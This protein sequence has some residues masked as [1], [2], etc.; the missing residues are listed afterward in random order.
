MQH[1]QQQSMS[2]ARV[3]FYSGA[4][5]P[6]PM[7]P[8]VAHLYTLI[9]TLSEAPQ[10]DVKYRALKEIS[11][12]LEDLVGTPA[13][14]SLV[15][16]LIRVFIKLLQETSP[17]FITENNT[18]QLRKL[19]LDL[20]LR[21][22]ANEMMKNYVK[23][24]QQI[25]L[26]LIYME[27]EENALIIIKILTDH[28][29]TFRPPFTPDLNTFFA[30]SKS[31]FNG[32]FA[33]AANEAMFLKRPFITTN[34][35]IEESV[36]E[37]L[38]TCYSSA[39]L[40]Y[41]QQH[42]Y[43]LV[44]RASQ[45]VK[46]LAEMSA[47]L[48]VLIQA[49]RQNLIREVVELIP[50]FVRYVNIAVPHRIREH[51]LY[52]RELVEEF[53]SS[54]VRALSFV[55]YT[56]R[57]VQM[58]P[59]IS[60]NAKALSDGIINLFDGFHGEVVGQ[61]RDLLVAIKYFFQC[62][63][64]AHFIGII[65]T[66]CD[67]N[68]LLGRSF[69]SQDQLR[70]QAYSFLA[71]I[72]H[73]VRMN[74]DQKL[75]M[76]IFFIASRNL[77]DAQLLPYVQT[78]YGKL[79][80][81]LIESVMVQ[82]KEH[83]KMF[84]EVLC[85]SLDSFVRKAKFVAEFH[86]PLI[87]DKHRSHHA[88]AK[89]QQQQQQ[90]QQQQQQ[91]GPSSA[92]EK[93]SDRS[94]TT[95]AF[96]ACQ[97]FW[98]DSCQPLA[99]NDCKNM[100]RFTIQ[101]VKMMVI[102]LK[103][104]G[105]FDQSGQ[106]FCPRVESDSL[107]RV[108]NLLS[109][110]FR[111]GLKC[112][113][114][115]IVAA[116]VMSYPKL[117]ATSVRSKEEKDTIEAF[118]S[119]YTQLDA[120]V[121][122]K[123]IEQHIEFLISRILDNPAL[124]H[125]CNS[126]FMH[127]PTMTCMGNVLVKFLLSKLSE[128]GG[129]SNEKAALHLKLFKLVFQAVSFAQNSAESENLLKPFLH[130]I[131]QDSMRLA[132]TSRES[133]NYFLLLRALFRSIGSGTHDLLYQQF[134]PL[135]PS[136]LQQL[137]RLQNGAHRQA[138]HELFVELCLTIPV[139]LSSLLP[140]LPLLMDPL[141]CALN[142]SPSLVQQGLRTLELCVDN[143]QPEYLYEHMMPVRG[144]LMSGL[145]R[146]V[147]ASDAQSALSA[148][149]ILGK[150]GGSNRK[151]L[152]DP[153]TWNC[154]LPAE[155]AFTNS[156]KL[157]I[158]WT[159]KRRKA[160]K[161]FP[162]AG[163]VDATMM[164]ITGDDAQQPPRHFGCKL[165][166]RETVQSAVSILRSQPITDAAQIGTPM[167]GTSPPSNSNLPIKIQ[168]VELIRNVL[169][170]GIKSA[171]NPTLIRRALSDAVKI[172]QTVPSF[173]DDD[174]RPNADAMSAFCC[175]DK[176]SRD[177]FVEALTGLFIAVFNTETRTQILPFFK[178][179]TKHLTVMAVL[180][181][182]PANFQP[183]PAQQFHCLDSSILIDTIVVT[184]G[185]SCKDYCHTAIVALRLMFDTA[186]SLFN[187]D[188]EKACHL[189][190]F[191]YIINKVTALCYRHEWFA[192]HG[193]C[194]AMRMIVEQYPRT[195]VQRH[196]IAIFDACLATI[197]GLSD[198]LSC[199]V[200]ESASRVVDLLL[201]VCFS[202]TPTAAV[203]GGSNGVGKCLDAQ[204]LLLSAFM[205]RLVDLFDHSEQILRK[206]CLRI[207]QSLAVKT[208]LPAAQLIAHYSGGDLHRTIRYK[209]HKFASSSVDTKIALIDFFLFFANID[210]FPIEFSLKE[211][212]IFA[213]NLL[214]ICRSNGVPIQ[215][216]FV[217]IPTT[218]NANSNAAGGV[219]T[220][221]IN[222]APIEA[223]DEQKVQLI[224][225]T[226]IDAMVTLYMKT[227]SKTFVS[228]RDE[229]EMFESESG[230]IDLR[231][232]QYL[233]DI[234]EFLIRCLLND[235]NEHLRE[236]A[237]RGLTKI[238]TEQ[239][240]PEHSGYIA[241]KLEQF[242]EQ[243]RNKKQFISKRFFEK[244]LF[245]TAHSTTNISPM[246]LQMIGNDL[247][248]IMQTSASSLKVD[249]IECV[250]K[251][252]ELFHALSHKKSAL[253]REAF[254]F[255]ANC[256]F[257]FSTELQNKWI[258]SVL[259]F[260]NAHSADFADVFLAKE[261][262]IGQNSYRFL[263]GLI[264]V[265][266][267]AFLLRNS[268]L[269]N[270]N[271]IK[272]F[273]SEI[274]TSPNVGAPSFELH[275]LNF[276]SVLLDHDEE[277]DFEDQDE[278]ID[279]LFGTIRSLW[280]SN[281]FKRRHSVRNSLL[282]STDYSAL[283]DD[284]P[285][286]SKSVVL[287][288]P[289]MDCPALCARI[290]LVKLRSVLN[291]I[292]KKEGDGGVGEQGQD[293]W[294][295]PL[296]RESIDLIYDLITAFD[297]CYASDFTFLRKF[298]DDEII[299]KSSLPW[300]R[301]TFTKLIDLLK[302]EPSAGRSVQLVRFVQYI[303]SPVFAYAFEMNDVDTVVCAEPSSFH[304][305]DGN[306]EQQQQRHHQQ[307]QQFGAYD[308]NI[309]LLLCHEVIHRLANERS[310]MSD[311]LNIVMYLFCSLVVQKCPLHI[312]DPAKRQ[313][314]NRQEQGNLRHFMLFAWPCLQQSFQ[315]DVTEKYAGHFL[316]A[317]IIDK[318]SIIK[319][320]ILQV[321]SSLMQSYHHDN[322]DLVRKSLEILIPALPRRMPDGYFR[323]QTLFKKIMVEEGRNNA[324]VVHC[325]QIIIRHHK[326]FYNI[327]HQIAPHILSALHRLFSL[328]L[329]FETRRLM[330]EVCEVVIKWEQDRQTA[331][332][333]NNNSNKSAPVNT[334]TTTTGD[335]SEGE[336][337]GSQQSEE[338]ILESSSP[339][340][341]QQQS[342]A[343]DMTTDVHKPMD[344]H[345]IDSIVT[346]IF[347]IATF[348]D[349]YSGQSST[350]STSSM[351]HINR[352][353]VIL[354]RSALKPTVFGD[355]ATLRTTII[356][357]QL[358]LPNTEQFGTG[359][360]QA[361]SHQLSQVQVTLDVLTNITHH[362][363]P[364]MI[365][366]I[367]RPL[368]R[369]LVT[370]ISY[371]NSQ[372]ILRSTYNVLSKLLEKTKCSPSGLDELDL[373]NHHVIRVIQD[374]FGNYAVSANA[375]PPMTTI[376]LL[377][378][379]HSAQPSY[380]E[381]VCLMP[382]VKLLQR[383][384]REYVVCNPGT[385]GAVD[386]AQKLISDLL[387]I[388][389][390]MLCTRTKFFSMESQRTI[391]QIVLIPL[392]EKGAVDKIVENIIKV[393]QEIVASEIA[394]SQQQ[395]Q[396]QSLAT[397]LIDYQQPSQGVLVLIKL[398]S[399]MEQRLFANAEL[400]RHF[401]NATI[402]VYEHEQLLGIKL[403]KLEPAFHWGL[404]SADR[405][406]RNKF[407]V[408]F[409]KRFP[410]DTAQRLLYIIMDVNWQL[411]DRY[412]W[413][414]HV[415][416]LL[417]LSKQHAD[418]R[419]ME[420]KQCATLNNTLE[421]IVG[422][423]N[424]LD[425]APHKIDEDGQ[426]MDEAVQ[427]GNSS[428]KKQRMADEGCLQQQNED[429]DVTLLEGGIQTKIASLRLCA[430]SADGMPTPTASVGSGEELLLL[431]AKSFTDQQQPKTTMID[432]QIGLLSLA[433]ELTTVQLIS[434]L[435]D[436]LHADTALCRKTF[437]ELFCSLWC[438]FAQN[439]REQV[440]LVVGPFLS[441][442]VHLCQR[443]SPRAVVTS[444]LEAFVLCSPPIKLEPFMLSY[445]GS[446]FNCWHV[447]LAQLERLAMN[448]RFSIADPVLM[449]TTE[450]ASE[451][452]EVL[453]CLA[454]LY[455]QLNELDQYSALWK[456]RAYFDK[457]AKCLT[458]FQQ[459]EFGRARE[460]AEKL[461][462]QLGERLSKTLSSDAIGAL[463]TALQAEQ[464]AWEQCWISS[465][466]QLNDWTSLE[467]FAKSDDSSD[468]ALAMESAW[469]L[470]DWNRLKD[471]VAKVDAIANPQTVVRSSMFQLM[472]NVTNFRLNKESMERQ[473]IDL[474]RT[475]IAEWRRLPP[476]VSHGHMDILNNSH[477]LHEISESAN[478]LYTNIPLLTNW[479][480]NSN[481]GSLN[482]NHMLNNAI[483]H[484]MKT[485]RNR[486]L[487]TVDQNSVWLDLFNW[488]LQ[489]FSSLLRFYDNSEQQQQ[490]Q[491]QSLAAAASSPP[492]STTLSVPLHAITQ[493]HLQQARAFRRSN[494]LDMAQIELNKLNP[495]ALLVHPMDAQQKMDE[496]VK[497]L[498]KLASGDVSS[499]A[500]KVKAQDAILE[501]LETIEGTPFNCLKRDQIARLMTNK[502]IL[503]SRMDK[504][505]EAGRAFS[506]AAQLEQLGE[507][508]IPSSFASVW[509]HWATFLGNLYLT[510]HTESSALNTG[511][512]AIACTLE[513]I[514]MVGAQK[515]RT[516]VAKLFWLLK[517]ASSC[518]SEKLMNSVDE[519]LLRY[520]D[521]IHPTNWLFWLHEIVADVQQRKGTAMAEIL[522]RVGLMYPQEV[523]CA[524]RVELGPARVGRLIE[525]YT[526]RRQL[527][528]L[529]SSDVASPSTVAV[530]VGAD[531]G[532]SEDGTKR[533]RLFGVLDAILR[534]HLTQICALNQMMD[535]LDNFSIGPAEA[536]LNRFRQILSDCHFDQF[537]KIG[538]LTTTPADAQ[539]L[540]GLIEW[541]QSPQI[542]QA[543]AEGDT[544]EGKLFNELLGDFD[545]CT[546]F[547]P[548][549]SAAASG[550]P[551]HRVAS[552]LRKWVSRI[553]AHLRS[554]LGKS[555]K[556]LADSSTFLAQ[557][558]AKMA[559]INIFDGHL[560]MGTS[561]QFNAQIAQFVP[562]FDEIVRAD[563]VFRL[564]RVRALNGKIYS[565]QL[566]RV[567]YD[568]SRGHIFQL[569]C[570]LN[571]EFAKRRDTARRFV[572][573]ALPHILYIGANCRLLRCCP[574]AGLS[575]RHQNANADH[576]AQNFAVFTDIMSE[577]LNNNG[578]GTDYAIEENGTLSLS[579]LAVIDQY[580]GRLAE[581]RYS[582][583][584]IHELFNQIC[585][586]KS[587][588]GTGGGDQHHHP[589]SA[590][591]LI[592]V[593]KDLLSRWMGQ[594]YGDATT[595]WMAR[596][597]LAVQIA[598]LGLSEHALFL[599]SMRPDGLFLDLSTGQLFFTDYKFDLTKKVCETIT[600]KVPFIEL[601]ANRPVP[602]RLTP[603]ISHFL[604]LSIDGHLIG[605]LTA[606]A[607]SLNALSLE[608]W[609]RPILWDV[610]AKA[611]E[612]DP[613]LNIVNPVKRAVDTIVGR[614]KTLSQFDVGM[615]TS[616]QQQL[617]VQH[618]MLYDNLCRMDP[619]WHPWHAQNLGMQ[620]PNNSDPGVYTARGLNL[621]YL[622]IADVANES[623][624]NKDNDD[625]G[626]AEEGPG[627]LYETFAQAELVT[628]RLKLLE[629]E[630]VFVP[631]GDSLK[632]VTRHYF[633]LS[634]NIG[635]QF[636]LFTSLC[637]W[638]I[639]LSGA[640]PTM[641]MPHEFDDPNA[642]VAHILDALKSKD[643]EIPFSAAKLKTGA[644]PQCLFVL[645]H[646]TGMAL[647]RVGF[648]FEAIN[649]TED[650][651][652]E[653]DGGQVEAD[654]AELNADQFLD[655]VEMAEDIDEPGEEIAEDQMAFVG[656]D[657]TSAQIGDVPLM[658]V[659]RSSAA[660]SAQMDEELKRVT[661]QLK[662]TVRANLKDWRMH[663]EQMLRLE[664]E[665]REQ[666]AELKPFM[667][668]T[669]E[670][671][672][673][674]M[675]RIR[676]R[677]NHL[678]DQF[679]S[680]LQ[681]YRKRQNE[682]AA[683][684][685]QY[686]ESSGT[687]NSQT[688]TLNTLNEEI[689]QLKQQIDEQGMQNTSGAPILKIKQALAKLDRDIVV[690]RV[691]SATVEQTL[692]KSQL[693]DR[694]NSAVPEYANYS[695]SVVY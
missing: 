7:S 477:L 349:Q 508:A 26:R 132:V 220:T 24:L 279:E 302:N 31:A 184:L 4:A 208:K 56:S 318:F 45:S 39:T 407:F 526:E 486:P 10:D 418:Q 668:R 646:L 391:I 235:D 207:F 506:A 383:L 286:S 429:A 229:G 517:I 297:H 576:S 377:R 312:Y 438:T 28:I 353:A 61:R 237:N 338:I 681:L 57:Q 468:A 691:Q 361:I 340:Q 202:A 350:S 382:F 460:M 675:E 193:G 366:D 583:K 602:F 566:E 446:T 14:A 483:K 16:S 406:L 328:Q 74:L 413:V 27:N 499:T 380:L 622:I 304:Q 222:L 168:A 77:H 464:R 448:I 124:Q 83:S 629:Y 561:P 277:W 596:K 228:P 358:Q 194:T 325:L 81:N 581:Q 189:P 610:F 50:I 435:V 332:E 570:L 511:I 282:S 392:I 156:P 685:E 205:T 42:Q 381:T 6:S 458:L 348:V 655:E 498:L 347:R 269:K 122:E 496:H 470:H 123:I 487:T 395:Q 673:Q 62:E 336:A 461:V 40:S 25:L 298:I 204:Q 451:K 135:L 288:V 176:F 579:P 263:M 416:H 320:I 613:Q 507:M 236:A 239:P 482:N 133:T 96:E 632:P 495:A 457:T 666:Y 469:H 324:Q 388:C 639:R 248:L 402:N 285:S 268:L 398:F 359:N 37:A 265:S 352:R 255:F 90:G 9:K 337:S 614:V 620:P 73:H 191:T 300:R 459:G 44:P 345:F 180:E 634:T 443:D 125:V 488:R 13:Y 565:Y 242:V 1:Q 148:L 679:S 577:M 199:G 414:A 2:P 590:S 60:D 431:E 157:A 638:L 374:S 475:M 215:P 411:M 346:F 444:F 251:A 310:M 493:C 516:S 386:Q 293:G 238:V 512:Q 618:S 91:P 34:K 48:F 537:T 343:G 38:K 389:L 567:R 658:E 636:H 210:E 356:E 274:N 231:G 355:V 676:M 432:M 182:N 578:S 523:F 142:G 261:F 232:P 641:K 137:N 271:L 500:K 266:G 375:S 424:M 510:N 654:E 154:R 520:V 562:H 306:I 253:L 250:A 305:L 661:P 528:S 291:S 456:R 558:N 339:T 275:L 695:Q 106:M 368:Q 5:V 588:A 147:Y 587:E 536:T 436:I 575:S 630:R 369:A 531:D 550:V 195:F 206:E 256:F 145:W 527:L 372:Q 221:D 669:G 65:P 609:L 569:F 342:T 311:S 667:A 662:V 371:I 631:L 317:N 295:S 151:A 88:D 426:Q 258:R 171:E 139:R 262:L 136:I 547:S 172:V 664:R 556:R 259:P 212:E 64:R 163:D 623:T 79:M 379:M 694:L 164:D 66:M 518:P 607:R 404:A 213:Q 169:L 680:L 41:S 617:L 524:L 439:E 462:A 417:L 677:E 672:E 599:S 82:P 649:A 52:N 112:L 593:Q 59:I 626:G 43:T 385:V 17:Q 78:M 504:R 307:Q 247:S 534:R 284:Q 67:D 303:V 211:L 376:T 563:S 365:I 479:S 532:G 656:S 200:I 155:A 624:Q 152:L 292:R 173:A 18:L 128:L 153:Q 246:E 75:L 514:W 603:N 150:F 111:Y 226:A 674:A 160:D 87:V 573:F 241:M 301:A 423:V 568:H 552:S 452:L 315:G 481:T 270:L 165:P 445:L 20:L 216:K 688:D 454:K 533:Q 33:H 314:G 400:Q 257:N 539:L 360:E 53:H 138:V 390:E 463:S 276:L 110:F 478:L 335:D 466:K 551:L 412:D 144:A 116:N 252:L 254:V 370:C 670:E 396:Q 589:S 313:H 427:D 430:I 102:A 693:S 549:Q 120:P 650:E 308:G 455:Q 260:M 283:G 409:E 571:A 58:A 415:V 126:F 68:A 604:G 98:Q 321:L 47:F 606:V 422:T 465:C 162:E 166:L 363:M 678:N 278:S 434:S 243:F 351:E 129:V 101:P 161:P 553:C 71:D 640:D 8:V 329:N 378:L 428:E 322:R 109:D 515:S 625:G 105:G 158:E 130:R 354:L 373:L 545:F 476:I 131:V 560:N 615:G 384:V 99:L 63:A 280:C 267:G 574:L 665:L 170:L 85:A 647:E 327:R 367:F 362:L 240:R 230:D 582:H 357:K 394:S 100:V 480:S 179:F 544:N 621:N 186:A 36:A 134:L 113:D 421:Q 23:V 86:L 227:V 660:D 490:Q 586:M 72:L 420:L 595:I 177:I 401:M 441:S 505:E 201:E 319:T 273:I 21:L 559:Q 687:L 503:L 95:K 522:K 447:A 32:M 223:A 627:R 642:T 174:N 309:V 442:A 54:Q 294:D 555:A 659:L 30:Q 612:D 29:K 542:V 449:N 323:L 181:S 196:S 616:S 209:M 214:F 408:V 597:K 405:E 519:K 217:G 281:S 140:Y 529:L 472:L 419:R 49:H 682:L 192:H 143:L 635:E 473:L 22:S 117:G 645:F 474:Y 628:E 183:T 690:M 290:L 11:E 548:Q 233:M 330:L 334:T 80:M 491:Q 546:A 326:V 15:D 197:S 540:K 107:H 218:T 245:F 663:A 287:D 541:L 530:V 12:R 55:A 393:S 364:K 244:L 683:I 471:R 3:V 51:K 249:D 689:E 643:I 497:C 598:L 190:L 433:N 89:Q 149:R 543:A 608:V 657:G 580:Y 489:F 692:W 316:I 494:Q 219:P 92:T 611:A 97:A 114:I 467:H 272:P 387:A 538:E 35:T 521:T 572:Q 644:G 93:C 70:N 187:G 119:T 289:T 648:H 484:M 437:V 104:L 331:V 501:A 585:G 94:D 225:T 175:A 344:K 103:N 671:I 601:D 203:D 224:K 84:R 651:L 450:P 333:D 440:E 188:R 76:H 141:V 108:V 296:V 684:T 198:E 492:A 535:E 653:N 564:F 485:W 686:R 591:S 146:T 513:H 159:P 234:F 557:F 637:A 425:K 592:T 115:F 600:G 69:T 633:V 554:T 341:Q 264:G 509:K 397:T 403:D 399:A 525:Q 127:Q 619:S 178:M 594:K 118:V 502:G 46:V 185:D 453:E 299:A 605:A 19:M 121:F 410:K 167:G 652:P 584:T